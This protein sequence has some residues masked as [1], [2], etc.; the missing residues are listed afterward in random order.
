MS[1]NVFENP[2]YIL[3]ASTRDNRRRISALAEEKAFLSDPEIVD[4]ARNALL[5]PQ[6]RLEAE[7]RW[8]LGVDDEKLKSILNFLQTFQDG[9]VPGRV[10]LS[11]V[12]SIALLNPK[13]TGNT[14][15]PRSDCLRRQ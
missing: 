4:E 10:D 2:F 6:K 9:S 1:M 15:T 7:L 14:G 3:G 11:G 8:F 5:I 12:K 13:S